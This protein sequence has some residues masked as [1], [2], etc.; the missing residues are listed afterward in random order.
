MQTWVLAVLAAAALLAAAAAYTRG[1]RP[2]EAYSSHLKASGTYRRKAPR[3]AA[4]A[5][6]AGP[7]SAAG[8]RSASPLSPYLAKAL[9]G[10][11]PAATAAE[12][13]PYTDDEVR[14]LLTRV[15]GRVNARSPG[16][17]L[18]LVSFDNV[19][20]TI[21]AYKTLRYEADVQVHSKARMYSSRLTAVVDVSS[22]GREYVR[23]LRV[24]AAAL[25]GAADVRAASEVAA[26]SDAYAT[27]EPAVR[28]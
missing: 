9:D 10:M 1:W 5:A 23:D 21:D 18:F 15:V 17:D 12:S 6:A 25:P 3:P 13:V 14:G 27:F 11:V 20:K 16:L 2:A 7:K 28:Y 4:T 19:K 24:H 8:P 26:A 22:A